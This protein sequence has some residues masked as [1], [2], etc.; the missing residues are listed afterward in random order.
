MAIKSSGQLSFTEIVAEFSDTAPHSMSEFYRGGGKVPTNN[1]NVPT[2]GA[3]SF[4]NFYNAVN[5]IVLNYIFSSN[6]QQATINPTSLPGYV[7]GI[8][9]VVITVNPGIYVWSDSTS[10]PGLTIG[11]ANSG[12]TI[13]L[14]NNG[15]IIGKGGNGPEAYENRVGNNGGPALTINYSVTIN[16]TNSSAY[17]AG[18]GGSGGV[19]YNAPTQAGAGGGAGGGNGSIVGTPGI[20]LGGAGGA[21]G[22]AGSNGSSVNSG[23]QNTGGGG[24]RILPG[25]GGV[26]IRY[27]NVAG[28][29]ATMY[30]RGGG[31]GASGALGGSST[32]AIGGGGGGWGASGAPSY[33][34]F[35]VPTNISPGDGGSANNNAIA[36][37]GGTITLRTAGGTGGKAVN[38]NGNSITWVSGDTSRIWGAVS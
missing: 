19:Y 38:L 34:R 6:T 2:S 36:A 23:A 31:A 1:T 28:F 3:I 33:S 15:Y 9:D 32:V 12:D 13:T 16:N 20:T 8:T 30:G 24:G 25:V 21:P 4:S 35:G 11:S 29:I 14:V 17:I 22:F 10:V 37:N 27:V 5:R 7:A 18:G 26:G